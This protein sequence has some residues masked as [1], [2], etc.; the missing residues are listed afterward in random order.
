MVNYRVYY[1]YKNLKYRLYFSAKPVEIDQEL[2]NL[3]LY[4]I[5]KV[6]CEVTEQDIIIL[7]KRV[8]R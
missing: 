4:E 5:H 2:V 8:R 3:A 7:E 1:N 6:H